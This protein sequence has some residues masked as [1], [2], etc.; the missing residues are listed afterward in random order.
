[1]GVF[2]GWGGG[3]G[4]HNVGKAETGGGTGGVSGG[5]EG[6]EGGTEVESE[7]GVAG[8]AGVGGK[9]QAG[10]GKVRGGSIGLG[11][12]KER[13]RSGELERRVISCDALKVY[14]AEGGDGAG[15]GAGEWA[16]QD[17]LSVRAHSEKFAL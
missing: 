15:G 13:N 6:D 16:E 1:M 9:A 5:T 7:A 12:Q 17:S 4:A 10:E 8:V 11:C 3:G 14:L 2:G